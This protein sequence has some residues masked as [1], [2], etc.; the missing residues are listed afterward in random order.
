MTGSIFS[1]VGGLGSVFSG[2]LA[3]GGPDQEFVPDVQGTYAL[4]VNGEAATLKPDL[5]IGVAN[6]PSGTVMRNSATFILAGIAGGAGN[7]LLLLGDQSGLQDQGVWL[8]D[9]AKAENPSSLVMRY[10]KAEE[11]T[12]TVTMTENGPGWT[13]PGTE[14]RRIASISNPGE[15]VYDDEGLE[16]EGFDPVGLDGDWWLYMEG[17]ARVAGI[18]QQGGATF[19]QL[20]AGGA[21]TTEQ[22]GDNRSRIE[23]SNYGL[24]L[25]HWRNQSTGKREVRLHGRDGIAPQTATIAA[26]DS[27]AHD[28]QIAFRRNGAT[29]EYRAVFGTTDTGWVALN[30]PDL[31]GLTQI[32][33]F[34]NLEVDSQVGAYHEA[35]GYL[36]KFYVGTAGKT[37]AELDAYFTG[38]EP[39]TN[40]TALYVQANTPNEK[41]LTVSAQTAPVEIQLEEVADAEAHSVSLEAELLGVSAVP[42]FRDA[43]LTAKV[44]GNVKATVA[45]ILPD[46]MT[47]W[48]D[49]GD[50]LGQPAAALITPPLW[51][52]TL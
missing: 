19:F 46:S 5:P 48:G 10:R 31:V 24:S 8:H 16:Y 37:Q 44:D 27:G 23:Y 49:M 33:F 32:R 47:L 20:D 6:F 42:G 11:T 36:N 52:V 12:E 4:G 1:G 29:R 7:D 9:D 41:D 40:E 51:K 38:G 39:A 25:G 28:I 13:Y 35:G 22:P 26:Q 45:A 14:I 3:R 2:I 50:P 15:V 34:P 17:T 21:R 43:T 30:I 18:D